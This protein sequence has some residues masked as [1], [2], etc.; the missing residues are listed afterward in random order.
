MQKKV[1][2]KKK[3]PFFFVPIFILPLCQTANK[4]K[5]ESFIYLRDYNAN[6]NFHA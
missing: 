4:A 5:T 1:K 6:E 2:K 3:Q